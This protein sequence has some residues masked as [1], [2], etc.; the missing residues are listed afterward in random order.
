MTL[1]RGGLL[2]PCGAPLRNR[3]AY[4]LPS[5]LP[6]PLPRSLIDHSHHEN[7]AFDRINIAYL[8]LCYYINYFVPYKNMLS[9]YSLQAPQRGPIS[10]PRIEW[11]FIDRA[12]CCKRREQRAEAVHLL[13]QSCL[14]P[15]L[16]PSLPSASIVKAKRTN[17]LDIVVFGGGCGVSVTDAISGPYSPVWICSERREE[18]EGEREREG[19]EDLI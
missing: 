7:V 10:N 13:R 9:T 1:A 2:N 16:P 18:G 19:S 3:T 5:P 4:P 11:H 8:F 15:S 17:A 6:L 14:H 12:E